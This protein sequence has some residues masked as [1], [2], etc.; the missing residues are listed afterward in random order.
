MVIVITAMVGLNWRL[1]CSATVNVRI[2][3]SLVQSGLLLLCCDYALNDR[4]A[5][6]LIFG[7]ELI[8]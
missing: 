2:A 4:R 6:R 8:V 1:L 3:Y 5:G 7:G